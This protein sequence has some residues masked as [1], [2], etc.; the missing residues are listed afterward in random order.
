M[1]WKRQCFLIGRKRMTYWL[2][3]WNNYVNVCRTAPATR[4]LLKSLGRRLK[5]S[6]GVRSGPYL[7]VATY[8]LNRPRVLGQNLRLKQKY[9]DF[10]LLDI[11]LVVSPGCRA[12]C[13]PRSVS[14]PAPALPP[15]PR[16]PSLSPPRPRP[17]SLTPPPGRDRLCSS[18][19]GGLGLPCW[20]RGR[21]TEQ[22]IFVNEHW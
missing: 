11:F 22:C 9:G 2:A 4:R 16:P 10:K 8:R 5:P 13:R 15:R 14:R 1:I 12:P 3:E 17:P 20:G 21:V 6:A 7:L 18:P 19:R